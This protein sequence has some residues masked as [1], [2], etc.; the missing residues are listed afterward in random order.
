MKFW[1]ATPLLR[2][3]LPFVA[4]IL[5]TLLTPLD[6]INL[7][8]VM[9]LLVLAVLF[10]GIIFFLIQIASYKNSWLFGCVFNLVVFS[11]GCQ[12]TLSKIEKQ[13]PNHFSNYLK[14][15]T[16]LHARIDEAIVEKDKSIKAVVQIFSMDMK[17]VF[18]SGKALV[19]FQK[20]ERALKLNYGD[21][22]ILANRFKEIAAP[23]NPDEF[24]Y[25]SLMEHKNISQQAIIKKSDWVYTGKNSGNILIAYS[26]SVRN[27][28]LEIFKQAHLKGDE[29]AVASALLIGYT[30]TLD[31]DLLSFYSQTGALH[32]LSVSGLHVGIVFMVLNTL[33]LFM[34]KFKFGKSIKAFILIFFLWFYAFISGLSPSVMRSATMLSF[35]VYGKSFKKNTTIVNTLIAS[36]LF[37]LLCNP[38]YILDIG[39]QL[40]Y[41]AVL[42]IV[43]IQP[44]FTYLIN[45]DNWILSQLFSLIAV[46]IAAQLG[47][48]P[49]CIYYFHQFPNY[50]LL[51]NLVAIPL[52]TCI[53]Y[54]GIALMIFSGN[55]YFFKCISIVFSTAVQ[56][57]NN[58]IRWIGQL[59]YATT[60]GLFINKPQVVIMYLSLILFIGYFYKKRIR[61]LRFFLWS[62]ITLF[63]VQLVNKMQLDNQR[64]FIVYA[65]PKKSVID[66]VFADE[67]MLIVDS[68]KAKL[69]N[70][71][72]NQLESYW[73]RLG[74]KAPVSVTENMKTKVIFVQ[75]E[76]IQFYDKRI[77]IL[78]N[79]EKTKLRYKTG[80]FLQV[81]YVVLSHDV[82]LSIEQIKTVY[83]PVCIVF[84]SS[85][86]LFYQL[87]KWKEACVRQQQPYY[88]VLEDGAFVREF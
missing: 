62:L 64:K 8:D 53:I 23:K 59:S 25:K 27:K 11:L 30:D 12:Y 56:L 75:D 43:Y 39:F 76:M 80:G 72:L 74:L 70:R 58:S 78:K 83:K 45:T 1:N 41:L 68:I 20:D 6:I 9:P 46:S 3:L 49:I 18:V 85:N 88:S 48:F 87:E 40:S 51:T 14:Q 22:L 55:P 77:V 60:N 13:Y 47:T 63:L 86:K 36:M 33:L 38:Y 28:L 16:L 26:I 32:I 65:I 35:M 15:A 10:L 73:M 4:G 82:R 50:F 57:L 24:D 67:H 54:L 42:S 69:I 79:D 5:V 29:F 61:Y 37:L 66:F 44:I 34:D 17:D 21:E 7:R 81:D 52:S 71:E 2:I 84:D 19:Y 31:A